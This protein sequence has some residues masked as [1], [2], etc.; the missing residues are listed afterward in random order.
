VLK[1]I[2]VTSF[3]IFFYRFKIN[4][5]ELSEFVIPDGAKRNSGISKSIELAIAFIVS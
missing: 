1:I 5:I 4:V 3:K 2:F